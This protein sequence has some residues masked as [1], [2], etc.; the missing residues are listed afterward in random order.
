[1]KTF[2]FIFKALLS[3]AVIAALIYGGVLCYGRIQK[4]IYPKKYENIVTEYAA[5]NGLDEN[6]V[7]A[8]MK[9]ESS[10]NPD[11]VSKSGAIGL[12]QLTPV[13]FEW[14]QTKT[15]TDYATD[16]LYEPRINVSFGCM[17]LRLH[18]DEFGGD[19]P[20]AIP[21]Y[22]AGR[23]IVNKWLQDGQYSADGKTLDRVPE[24]NKETSNYTERVIN[25]IEKY[26][27]IYEDKEKETT[28]E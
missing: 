9:C 26:K 18:L 27:N 22:H 14:L 13:T 3:L 25:T 16:R 17:L 21:A 28:Y 19:I 23:G 24:Q 11:A 5:E 12:M 2:K 4:M 10:F 8:V 1:M 6:L 7:Y 20:T 15:G